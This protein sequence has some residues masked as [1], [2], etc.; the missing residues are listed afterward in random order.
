MA[1]DFTNYA[2]S[3]L[4][5]IFSM[6]MGMAYPLVNSSIEEI[7]KKYGSICIVQSFLLEACYRHFQVSLALSVIAAVV[8]PFILLCFSGYSSLIIVWTVIHTLIV[9]SLMV[10]AIRLYQTLMEYKLPNRV[11]D[12][13]SRRIGL[14]D[15]IVMVA[16]LAR[17]AARQNL[18]EL[19]LN[20]TQSVCE[21]IAN[22]MANG[23]VQ[24]SRSAMYNAWGRESRL[25]EAAKKAI[26]IYTSIICDEGILWGLYK[27]DISIIATILSSDKPLLE[28]DRL[29]IWRFVCE[30]VKSGNEKWLKAYWTQ[31][32]QY[33]S[34]FD[35][36]RDY[37]SMESE[38]RKK[39]DEEKREF[40]RMH[41]VMIGM[42]LEY[43]KQSYVDAL[44][45]YSRTLP[46]TYPLCDNTFSSLY[47]DWESFYCDENIHWLINQLNQ[48]PI[49][50]L[51]GNIND[52]W[53]LVRVIEKSLA[54]QL[55]RLKGMDYNAE[56]ADPLELIAT[57]DTIEGK[58]YQLRMLSRMQG[59]V[60][61]LFDEGLETAISGRKFFNREEAT[62]F[63]SRNVSKINGH[64]NQ[65]INNPAIDENKRHA[66]ISKL[67]E[68]WE[69]AQIHYREAENY[70]A[71]SAEMTPCSIGIEIPESYILSGYDDVNYDDFVDN[72][73]HG[74]QS[75]VTRSFANSFDYY[76]PKH[77]FR[78]QY[79]DVGK[80]LERLKVNGNYIILCNDFYIDRFFDVY[81]SDLFRRDDD[82][83]YFNDAEMI[84]VNAPATTPFIIVIKKSFLPYIEIGEYA[85][86]GLPVISDSPFLYSNLSTI[87]VNSYK[88]TQIKFM[89]KNN[90]PTN[91]EYVKLT[92]PYN[93]GDMDL[94]RIKPI[95]YL[96]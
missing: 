15:N 1:F 36:R 42:I 35:Q 71:Y 91:M 39:C 32:T 80:A 62:D 27:A 48:Y 5:T 44:L 66:L 4:I 67:K 83:K 38:N 28:G 41:I 52:E 33:I 76:K 12:R 21:E 75:M 14:E 54:L 64:M 25:T 40:K 73:I 6:I 87:D 34:F 49:D 16:E 69:A 92:M 72:I 53:R 84:E 8:S 10:S 47:E 89:I 43:G 94:Y 70:V 24:M 65:V 59:A 46:Y 58:Q 79:H 60:N 20:C 11:A 23:E 9:L 7:D 19:Y 18:P 51:S 93:L 78:I 22:Q 55:I 17:F 31:A 68:K 50:G 90:I 63:I 96:E 2:F 95:A 61:R 82:K 29:L 26:G 37:W 13:L 30:A 81:K 88:H 57:A 77:L 45:Y 86:A 56:Y 85:E 74:I 3:A